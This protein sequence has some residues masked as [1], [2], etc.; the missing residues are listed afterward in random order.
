[1]SAPQL[2]SKIKIRA[3]LLSLLIA[4]SILFMLRGEPEIRPSAGENGPK[5]I[6]LEVIN[7][8]FT[9]GKTVPSVFLRVFSDGT[10]KGHTE[11]FWEEADVTKTKTLDAEELEKLR[12]AINEPNLSGIKKRYELMRFVI[13][14]WMEWDITIQHPRGTQRIEVVSFSPDAA[15][16]RNQPYPDA[17]VKLGCSILK[18]RND[19]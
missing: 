8:H 12:A 15:R 10:A 18:T 13:D 19:V 14:S 5:I 4:G 17:L 9:V 16:E 2:L 11:K 6:L 7:K 3:A 1:M